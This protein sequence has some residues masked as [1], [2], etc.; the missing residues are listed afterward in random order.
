MEGKKKFYK[1]R[2]EGESVLEVGGPA[3]GRGAG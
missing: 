2:A 3:R 1:E